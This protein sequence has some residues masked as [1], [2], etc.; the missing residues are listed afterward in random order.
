MQAEAAPSWLA[1]QLCDK[2]CC[3]LH[4]CCRP[5]HASWLWDW[6]R[7]DAPP[8][9]YTDS[10]EWSPRTFLDEI[11]RQM[12]ERVMHWLYEVTVLASVQSALHQGFPPHNHVLSS[13]WPE[14]R[15]WFRGL[16]R[17]F[18]LLPSWRCQMKLLS[19]WG[20]CLERVDRCPEVPMH[21]KDNPQRSAA[22]HRLNS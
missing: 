22:A 14:V 5:F 8:T 17:I 1:W 18:L 7:T 16:T 6:R 9:T 2:Q 3:V 15:S 10:T 19:I 12:A 11:P 13:T 4:R 21:P 20:H